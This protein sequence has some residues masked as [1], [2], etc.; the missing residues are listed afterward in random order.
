MLASRNENLLSFLSSYINQML[1]CLLQKYSESLTIFS[2]HRINT[3]N[4]LFPCGQ[5][6]ITPVISLSG[7]TPPPPLP[8]LGPLPGSVDKRRRTET[9]RNRPVDSHT[10]RIVSVRLLLS[11]DP[12]SGP[13]GG[14]GGGGG[15][16]RL[17]NN[18]SY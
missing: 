17:G 6:S 14:R 5:S 7:P 13:S 12:G 4:C 9:M 11:T 18:W 3:N 1:R 8:P 16:T 10:I 2:L 15:R